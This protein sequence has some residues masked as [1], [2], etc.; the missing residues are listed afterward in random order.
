MISKCPGMIISSFLITD[1][2][3]F[4]S[5]NDHKGIWVR[6]AS[7][8]VVA[9]YCQGIWCQ[10]HIWVTKAIATWTKNEVGCTLLTHVLSLK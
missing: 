1:G 5:A 6:T 10:A 3:M 4:Q 8:D 7:G 2:H 9:N